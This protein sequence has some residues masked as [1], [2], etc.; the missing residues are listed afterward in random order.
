MDLAP[1]NK[2]PAIIVRQERPIN[3]EPSLDWLV[4]S[5][6]TPS[7]LFFVRNHGDIPQ[8]N[9]ETFR[10]EVDG[11]VGRRLS[12]SL[13]ELREC[14]PR[15]E[16]AATLQCAGNRR[17]EM[18]AFQPI[19]GELGWDAGA[20]SHARWAGA[21]LREVLTAAAISSENAT[22]SHVAFSGM[23]ETER[24]GRRFTFGG[25][26]P[27]EKALDPD[28]LLAYEMN[29]ALLSPVHGAPVRVITPGYIGARSVKWLNRITVQST[30]SDNYFQAH[31]YRLF[32]AS[33]RAET[34]NWEAGLM[35]GEMSVNSVICLPQVEA[36]L[37]GGKV[38]VSGYATAGGGR[39]IARVEL[40]CDNELT[41]R[42]AEIIGDDGRWSW[43]F[44]RVWLDLTPGRNQLMVRAVDSAANIQ[45]LNM[46]QVWN[47]KGY[48]N[49]VW[50]RIWI[51][52]VE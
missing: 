27:L 13:T 45:P 38:Q 10:L 17:L 50:H 25:S 37:G 34:V 42:E 20:I 8:V 26:I 52:I 36:Q 18:A 16:V 1:L 9:H 12:L 46:D 2:H 6:I 41:W 3:A 11:Q 14:F 21:S 49:N 43:K 33:A 29:G 51:D 24:Q 44:W 4:Q 39:Q 35:L 7:E 31:A 5:L 19:P 32:P 28:T 48:M 40:S 23:D 15:R 30:P 47:F 22:G